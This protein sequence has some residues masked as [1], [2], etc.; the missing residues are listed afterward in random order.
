MWHFYLG[1][2]LTLVQISPQGEMKKIILGSNV[3]NDQCLQYVVPAGH[4]FGAYPNTET[5]YS[6]V[7]CTVHQV[8]I[9]L[10]LKWEKETSF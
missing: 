8:L 3:K 6:F 1:G 9:L 10:I 2:P 4:W 5:E 7:G